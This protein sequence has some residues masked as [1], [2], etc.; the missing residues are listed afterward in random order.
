MLKAGYMNRQAVARKLKTLIH[1]GYSNKKARAIA[2]KYATK[3]AQVYFLNPHEDYYTTKEYKASLH[4]KEK[5]RGFLDIPTEEPIISLYF[6]DQGKIRIGVMIDGPGR[7]KISIDSKAM[8]S[9]VEDSLKYLQENVGGSWKLNYLIVKD[10]IS[11]KENIILDFMP[12]ARLSQTNPHI[13]HPCNKTILKEMDRHPDWSFAEIL[14]HLLL[15]MEPKTK[16]YEYVEAL[17]D[18][19]HDFKANK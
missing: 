6:K 15:T 9:F 18:L 8:I 7:E 17:F 10:T 19:V 11:R 14:S 4:L 16:D 1:E 12:R 5:I 13:D 3:A 2:L